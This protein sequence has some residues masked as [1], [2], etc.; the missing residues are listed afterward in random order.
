M[1]QVP[2]LL[3]TSSWCKGS[4][5]SVRRKTEAPAC[6]QRCARRRRA[7]M[8]PLEFDDDRTFFRVTFS[9]ETMLDNVTVEWLNRFSDLDLTD[10]QRLAMAYNLSC[11]SSASLSMQIAWK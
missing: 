2:N 5:T 6:R 9:N 10:A 1:N 11:T 3:A 8:S 4:R 7:Q